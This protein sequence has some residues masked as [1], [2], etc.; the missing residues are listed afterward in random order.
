MTRKLMREKKARGRKALGKAI[1]EGKGHNAMQQ[2]GRKAGI[3]PR[4][5]RGLLK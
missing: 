1:V 2:A 5:V 3:E 4:A